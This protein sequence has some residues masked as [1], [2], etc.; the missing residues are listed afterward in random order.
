VDKGCKLPRNE[1]NSLVRNPINIIK[2]MLKAVEK[3]RKFDAECL[4]SIFNNFA[5]IAPT[6]T[7]INIKLIT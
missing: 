6:I 4:L 1:R 2:N 3:S 5:G 7:V